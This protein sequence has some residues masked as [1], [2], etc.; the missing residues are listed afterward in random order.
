[1]VNTRLLKS[2]LVLRG[3]NLKTM[4]TS[5]G[6]NRVTLSE[7]VNGRMNFKQEDIAKI[8]NFLH[9]TPDEIVSIFCLNGEGGAQD[10]G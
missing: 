3:E 6:F 10:V 7:K 9:L 1:M 5:C 8:A 2:T 4:G